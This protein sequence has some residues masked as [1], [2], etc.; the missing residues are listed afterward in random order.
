MDRDFYSLD[1]FAERNGI[2]LTTTYLE[3]KAGRLHAH[4]LGRRTLI[5]VEDAKAWREQLPKVRAGAI[6]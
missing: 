5:S 3:I 1:E 6:A 2:G 4:K